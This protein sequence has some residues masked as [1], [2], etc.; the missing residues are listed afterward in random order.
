MGETHAG[1]IGNLHQQPCCKR[2]LGVV[3]QVPLGHLTERRPEGER[4]LLPDDD[5]DRQESPRLRVQPGY[6]PLD[7]LA[8]QH[9]HRHALQVAEEPATLRIS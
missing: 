3:E 9:R 8:Q 1:P 4:D 5:G 2:R 7:D 6:P